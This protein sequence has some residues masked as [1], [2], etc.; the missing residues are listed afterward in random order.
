[1]PFHRSINGRPAA[2]PTA[3][4]FDAG[5][6]VTA[7]N[8]AFAGLGVVAKDQ[9][10]P[11]HW[12]MKVGCVVLD[13]SSPTAKQDV[14]D[15]HATADSA[16]VTA[17]LGAAAA[18]TA[19]IVPSHC[20]SNVEVPVDVLTAPT[21]K[22]TDAEGQATPSNSLNVEP[23]GVG[24]GVIVHAVPSQCSTSGT[25]GFP[26]WPTAKQS[27]ALTHV[28]A[29]SYAKSAPA[30][31]GA[32]TSAQLVPFHASTSGSGW[33]PAPEFEKPHREAGRRARA[34]H[35]VEL[36]DSRTRW[37]RAHLDRP[38]SAVPVLDVGRGS[39]AANSAAPRPRST[40]VAPAHASAVNRPVGGPAGF[41]LGATVHAARRSRA[42]RQ[43][44]PSRR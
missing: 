35:A 7:S 11:D 31:V 26:D 23:A 15:T 9:V 14:A 2:K 16:G 3:K 32:A 8:W 21:A 30:G 12:S 19:Q 1:M 40:T 29:E 18:P 41:A 43:R 22:Q 37:V 34:R 44:P 33:S 27:V 4:Q 20:S 10:V 42:L 28:T 25:V 39:G 36:A 38:P 17:P 6:H 24:L 13:S 5:R